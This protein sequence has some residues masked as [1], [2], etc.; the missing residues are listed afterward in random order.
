MSLLCTEL[1]SFGCMPRS[2]ITTANIICIM[3]MTKIPKVFV[4]QNVFYLGVCSMCTWECVFC[5]SFVQCPLK[6]SLMSLVVL[7]SFTYIIAFWVI[8][9]QLTRVLNYLIAA[10]LYQFCLMYF[11]TVVGCIWIENAFFGKFSFYEWL[12]VMLFLFLIIFAQKTT[13]YYIQ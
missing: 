9:Y 13:F 10:M 12:Y 8:L 2:G 6:H 11:I 3:S 1:H 4:I 7:S 5:Y